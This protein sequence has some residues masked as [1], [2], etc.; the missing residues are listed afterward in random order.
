MFHF[1]TC[2][3]LAQLVKDSPQPLGQ[4]EYV[5]IKDINHY[6]QSDCVLILPVETMLISMTWGGFNLVKLY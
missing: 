5:I 2:D 4:K 1:N 3:C 6:H